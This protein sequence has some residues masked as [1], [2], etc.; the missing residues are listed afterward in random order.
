MVVILLMQNAAAHLNLFFLQRGWLCLC[1]VLAS[2]SF[3]VRFLHYFHKQLGSR[4]LQGVLC[5]T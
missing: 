3:L 1:C 4:L 5:M 2:I